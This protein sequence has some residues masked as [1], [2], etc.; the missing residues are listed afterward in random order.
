MLYESQLIYILQ[1][2]LLAL[3]INKNKNRE[4]VFMTEVSTQ[5]H[6]HAQVKAFNKHSLKLG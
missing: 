1:C 4:P 3:P 5:M 6:A 2:L